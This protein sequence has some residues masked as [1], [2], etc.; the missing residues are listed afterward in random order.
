M[1]RAQYH[2]VETYSEYSEQCD[3]VI[4]IEAQDHVLK[5]LRLPRLRHDQ[6]ERTGDKER[7]AARCPAPTQNYSVVVRVGKHFGRSFS[8]FTQRLDVQQGEDGRAQM[9]WGMLWYA[10]AHLHTH[11]PTL[12]HTPTPGSPH[13]TYLENAVVEKSGIFSPASKHLAVDL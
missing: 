5:T 6:V 1:D 8:H 4:K 9:G 11:T 7:H 3:D 12:L 13:S 2:V 10:Y